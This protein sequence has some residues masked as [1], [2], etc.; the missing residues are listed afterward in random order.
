MAAIPA[1]IHVVVDTLECNTAPGN[2]LTRTIESES[3]ES[4]K[5]EITTMGLDTSWQVFV[6]LV[7]K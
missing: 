2:T 6:L 1:G 7:P 4:V 5:A 3:S